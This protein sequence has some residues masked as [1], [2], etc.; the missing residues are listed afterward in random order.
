MV[1]K[2]LS[3][4]SCD[5]NEF[6]KAKGAYETALKNSGHDPH[7]QY[8]TE[9]T[10]RR[11][12]R[13]VVWFNPPFSKSVETD[14]GRKFLNLIRKHFSRHHHFYQYFNIHTLKLS[15]S[16]MPNMEKIIKQSNTRVM[17]APVSDSAEDCNCANPEE[18]SLDGKCLTPSVTYTADVTTEDT[19][20]VYHG[21]TDGVFKTRYNG[22]TSSF[23]L[24]HHENDTV[25]SKYIWSLKD[26]GQ[27][28][29]IK[30]TIASKAQ[31]Y[32][33]GTRRCD[34]CLSE[35]TI[36]AR[37]T[38]PCMLNKRTEI[39]GKCRHQ[40]KFKLNSVLNQ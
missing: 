9:K 39:V 27:A 25:L 3:E 17:R 24:R 10:K 16:C 2:R 4:L 11:R 36:I 22:H 1:G 23:R 30:W 5:E 6:N 35:K 18:C 8:N 32:K 34:V 7:L 12:K 14:I 29:S 20:A 19:N 38:H 26:S 33:C 31:P 37:S 15:Y 40:M 13:N 28:H 21:S